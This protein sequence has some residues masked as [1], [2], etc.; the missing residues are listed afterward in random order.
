MYPLA[1][2]ALASA[3]LALAL[4]PACGSR[5]PRVDDP[6]PAPEPTFLEL[7]DGA[8]G[9]LDADTPFAAETLAA[10][11]PAS[12]IVDADGMTEGERYPAL[13]VV[14]EEE[15]LL[16]IR[17]R[18]GARIS[19]V[20]ILDPDAVAGLDLRRGATFAEVFPPGVEPGCDPGVE[21]ISGRVV[22]RAPSSP[23]ILLV[24]AGAWDGPDGRLPPAGTLAAWTLERIV[25]RP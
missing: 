23:Q 8:L 3:L 21:E 20:E 1:I 16:E 18:D 11:F 15:P 14:R 9:P 24:F 22:C 4:L 13:R 17:S 19:S 2:R 10:A 12:T 25:W 7:A 5:E 6:A